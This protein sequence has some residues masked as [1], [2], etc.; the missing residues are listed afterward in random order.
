MEF[1]IS[2]PALLFSAI[3]LLM[4]AYTNR[5]LAL[6]SLIR[7]HIQLYESGKDENI[8][9]QIQNFK[10]RL[11]IIKYT[12]IFGVLSFLLCVISMFLIFLNMPTAAEIVF[13]ASLIALFISLAVS[14]QE[15]FLSIGA[16]NIEM[17]RLKK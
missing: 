4:L 9:K 12:Q 13:G 11:N 1:T 8:L 16:L 15:I 17:N 3:S 14:L 5:F 2:T 6:A 10:K 7:Q